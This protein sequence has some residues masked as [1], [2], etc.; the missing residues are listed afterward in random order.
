M[1]VTPQSYTPFARTPWRKKR[2]GHSDCGTLFWTHRHFI[3]FSEIIITLS[4]EKRTRA[5]SLGLEIDSGTA[6]TSA[7][8][9][10]ATANGE[11]LYGKKCF[12]TYQLL[13]AK[14]LVPSLYFYLKLIKIKLLALFWPALLSALAETFWVHS[15]EVVVT[16]ARAMATG[17]SHLDLFLK[18]NNCTDS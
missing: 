12:P 3:L 4:D 14:C 17:F 1:I 18:C 5:K 11:T 15:S 8:S 2:N 10:W 9:E 7:N 16:A 6:L 13:N